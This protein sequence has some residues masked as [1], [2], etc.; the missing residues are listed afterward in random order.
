MVPADIPRFGTGPLPSSRITLHHL[1]SDTSLDPIPQ[2]DARIA[3]TGTSL[4][5]TVILDFMYGVAAYRRWGS[6]Q[7]I[8]EVM[9]RRFAERYESVPIT[10]TPL[11]LH[12]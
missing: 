7:D 10:P 12:K 3:G 5:S 9:E 2:C 4:P 11:D 6:G 8:K 1:D